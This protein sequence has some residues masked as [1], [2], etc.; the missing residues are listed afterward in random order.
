MHEERAYSASQFKGTQRDSASGSQAGRNWKQL[1]TSRH[2]HGQKRELMDACSQFTFSCY[3]AQGP[4]PGDGA[5]HNKPQN[6]DSLRARPCS[7]VILER[8]KLACEITPH[9]LTGFRCAGPVPV[10]ICMLG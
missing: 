10:A 5:A 6:E 9:Q 2:T 7:Q 3:T 1:V 8:I 4:S